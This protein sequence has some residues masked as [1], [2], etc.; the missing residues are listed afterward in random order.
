MLV[1]DDE[2]IGQDDDVALDFLGDALCSGRRNG[3]PQG[4]RDRNKLRHNQKDKESRRE[5]TL[6]HLLLRAFERF[7]DCSCGIAVL[8]SLFF[9]FSTNEI[10]LPCIKF[11]ID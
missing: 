3:E 6:L 10:C 7:S 5:A 4:L 9:C 1:G 2:V 8:R 11:K